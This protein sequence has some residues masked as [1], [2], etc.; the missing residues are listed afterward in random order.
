MAPRT[1]A[2]PDGKILLSFLVALLTLVDSVHLSPGCL[3]CIV[4]P[5]L[6][7]PYRRGHGRAVTF[8]L[9]AEGHG[10]SCSSHGFLQLERVTCTY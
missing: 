2:G 4:P 5:L 10:L 9:V 3:M 1:L 6:L 7:F 8:P